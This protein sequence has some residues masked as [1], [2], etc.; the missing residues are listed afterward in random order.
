MLEPWMSM[1]HVRVFPGL[2]AV[3]VLC[4]MG[5]AAHVVSEVRDFKHFVTLVKE[6]TGE[7]VRFDLL[8]AHGEYVG[9]QSGF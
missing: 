9:Q 8:K 5:S 7:Y 3:G 2:G 6:G 4:R 1:L